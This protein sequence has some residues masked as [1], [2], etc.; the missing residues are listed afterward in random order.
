MNAPNSLIREKIEDYTQSLQEKHGKSGYQP[1]QY[2]LWAEMLVWIDWFY[3][4][5]L[6]AYCSYDLVISVLSVNS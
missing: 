4:E 5:V 2:R 1:Y 6:A 3:L